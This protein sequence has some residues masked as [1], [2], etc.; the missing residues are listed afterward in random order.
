MGIAVYVGQAEQWLPTTTLPCDT[1]VIPKQ[2]ASRFQ[3]FVDL[4]LGPN[5]VVVLKA[6]YLGNEPVR[7][8]A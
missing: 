6:V 4:Q 7:L 5:V 3:S 2:G 8:L 1:H